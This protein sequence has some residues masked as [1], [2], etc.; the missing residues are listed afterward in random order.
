MYKNKSRHRWFFSLR[1]YRVDTERIFCGAKRL[2]NSG[3]G[4]AQKPP[5]SAAGSGGIGANSQPRRLLTE[6]RQFETKNRHK[7]STPYGVLF[8]WRL[9]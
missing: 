3:I 7:K 4:R 9:L 5:S 6:N 1:P 8:P 2:E